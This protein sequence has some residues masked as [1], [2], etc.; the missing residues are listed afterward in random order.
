MAHQHRTLWIDEAIAMI[1]GV[2]NGSTETTDWDCEAWGVRLSAKKVLI[3][4]TYV[5]SC[6]STVA[7]PAFRQA[8]TAWRGFIDSVPVDGDTVTISV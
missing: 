3:Y 8:L 4:S 7:M 1:D 5:E 2:L 6:S